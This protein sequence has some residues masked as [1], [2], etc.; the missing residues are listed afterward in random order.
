MIMNFNVHFDLDGQKIFNYFLWSY[1]YLYNKLENMI[2][3]QEQNLQKKTS[4][5]INDK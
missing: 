2:F 3:F 5:I 1:M 4:L